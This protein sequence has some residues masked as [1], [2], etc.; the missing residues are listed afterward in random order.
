MLLDSPPLQ[1]DILPAVFFPLSG[2][3]HIKD[4]L[5]GRHSQ[6]TSYFCRPG[7]SLEDIVMYIPLSLTSVARPGP[8]AAFIS[9]INL[10]VS[11]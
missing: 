1:S 3:S 9:L 11:L 6:F 5:V 10:D 4:L 8:T 7:C 2:P